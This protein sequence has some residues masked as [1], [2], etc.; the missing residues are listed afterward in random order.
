MKAIQIISL[1]LAAGYTVNISA[2][3]TPKPPPPPQDVNVVNTPDVNVINVPK[4]VQ[5]VGFTSATYSGG[6]GIIEYAR[7]CQQEFPNSR[8][9]TTQEIANQTSI[10]T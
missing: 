6:L 10:T 2:A 7:H 3:P 1:I 5:L 8:M 4:S 9:C